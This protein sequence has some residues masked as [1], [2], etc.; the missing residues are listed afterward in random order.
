M[1]SHVYKT[2]PL[3]PVAETLLKLLTDELRTQ[4]D[5]AEKDWERLVV[6]L[7]VTSCLIGVRNGSRT[8]R[9]FSEHVPLSTRSNSDLTLSHS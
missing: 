2:E 6:V 5:R 7:K 1:T 9:E 3:E 4:R 8:P